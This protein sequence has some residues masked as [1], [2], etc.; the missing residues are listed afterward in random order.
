MDPNNL[1]NYDD[2]LY[3]IDRT[4]SRFNK[5]CRKFCPKDGKLWLS[6]AK[7]LTEEQLHSSLVDVRKA[8]AR[9]HIQHFRSVTI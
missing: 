4:A 9:S 8:I 2:Q 1:F 7:G 6:L 3:L 5:L